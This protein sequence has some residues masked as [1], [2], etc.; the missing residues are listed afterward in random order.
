MFQAVAEHSN[1]LLTGVA[2]ASGSPLD[3]LAR[4][5]RRGGVP[6][7]VPRAPQLTMHLGTVNS[8]DLFNGWVDFQFADPSGLVVPAVRFMQAYSADNPPQVGHTVWALHFGTDLIVAGQHVVQT[9]IVT[10]S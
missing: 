4:S 1:L 5:V 10:P 9:N 8:V 7:W 6:A 3:R 2:M